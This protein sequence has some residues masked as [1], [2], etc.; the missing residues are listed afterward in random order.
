MLVTARS[1]ATQLAERRAVTHQVHVRVGLALS[2]MP[3]L[4]HVADVDQVL[5]AGER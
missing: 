1:T 5:A 4:G 2:Y 3:E